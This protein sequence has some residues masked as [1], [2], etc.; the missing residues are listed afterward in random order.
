MKSLKIGILFVFIL[1][2]QIVKSQQ[3]TR[4]CLSSFGAVVSSGNSI[5]MS[6]TGGQDAIFYSGQFKNIYLVQGFQ[7]PQTS[8][9]GFWENEKISPM[10]WP[11]PSQ[12]DFYI[13]M[14]FE[15][16]MV[17]SLVFS[18]LDGR[19]VNHMVEQ[20]QDGLR[21]KLV[22]DV[23]PGMYIVSAKTGAVSWSKRII[24]IP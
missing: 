24:I 4:D 10:L 8:K 3:I 9:S 19:I 11:N 13:Y 12:G 21:V 7:Q 18:S 22:E 14:D 6:Q 17:T 1:V 2:V 5:M 15:K 20:R 23:A 16:A